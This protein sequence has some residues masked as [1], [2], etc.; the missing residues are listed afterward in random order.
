[1]GAAV[2]EF[3]AAGVADAVRQVAPRLKDF[4]IKQ[5]W[6][7]DKTRPIGSVG[8]ADVM[9]AADGDDWFA[10]TILELDAADSEP[11]RYFVPVALV[12][13]DAVDPTLATIA[14]NGVIW[15]VGDA[16]RLPA[17]HAW[18]LDQAATAAELTGRFGEIVWHA[19]PALATLLPTARVAATQLS[20]AEQS[21]TSVIFGD[22]L[23]LKAF[24]RLA[25]GLNPDVEI[26]RYLATNTSFR[27]T[28]ILA[29]D[30]VYRAADGT[31][32]SLAMIQSFEASVGDGWAFT[33]DAVTA[34]DP[35]P[36]A[37]YPA[38]ARVL[39][40]RTG[41]LHTALARDDA[42]KSFRPEPVTAADVASWEE[43]LVAAVDGML[44]LS[45]S[46]VAEGGPGEALR[47]LA[48]RRDELVARAAGF[49][50][51]VGTTKIR[52]H[53][54]YHLG[55]VLR[56]P[57]DD[58]ILLDF[59]GE[60]ARPLAE[61]RQKSSPLKD[62]AGML[63]SFAYAHGAALR[64][65]APAEALTAWEASART[66]FLAG[67]RSQTVD[68]GGTFV[69]AEDDRFARALDAWELDKAVY[70]LAYELNNRPDWV[71][72]PLQALLRG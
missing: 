67:Y 28:P 37:G 70:E 47:Q 68:R 51:L 5:R 65:G 29:A 39:G 18:L 9:V 13:G 58:F 45:P 4:V 63:R 40:E 38:A 26:G 23:M 66:A 12:R 20:T 54:D 1:M 33:L 43:R 2:G 31:E 34:A 25:P 21:N 36:I 57:T 62:V 61:R 49:R 14:A 15:R 55:Q 8:I 7:G 44:A 52:V 11:L 17:F 32:W 6:F 41:Q 24:R 3:D 50:E 10:L 59:E 16:F 64:A 69:P 72:I 60:P 48:A 27:N 35:G 71:E 56:T 22:A 19:N 30:A 46:S 53:G 42:N